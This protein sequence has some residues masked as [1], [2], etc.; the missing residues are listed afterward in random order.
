MAT[1]P[2]LDLD[3]RRSLRSAVRWL[4]GVYVL[5]FLV[6]VGV[7]S[8][9]SRLHHERLAEAMSLAVRNSLV[10]RD[11]R[12]VIS[13]LNPSI[14]QSFTEIGFVSSKGEPVFNLP[15]LSVAGISRAWEGVFKGMIEIPIAPA[16][17]ESRSDET[18]GILRFSYSMVEPLAVSFGCWLFFLAL[19]V[20][21]FNRVRLFIERRHREI[22]QAREAE[23]LA[24][25]AH[26]VSHDIRSPLSA[27][28]M[29]VNTLDGIPPE[30]R[31]IIRLASER[32][33]DIANDLLNRQKMRVPFT[34][35]ASGGEV[36]SSLL[37]SVPAVSSG[38]LSFRK[39]LISDLLRDVFSEKQAALSD[40]HDL[41]LKLDL[42][43]P[44][45]AVCELDAKEFSRALSNL[46]NNAAEAIEGEGCV[47]LALRSSQKKDIAVVVSDDGRGIPEA[48]LTRLGKERVTVGKEGTGSGSGVGV[49]HAKSV[50]EAMG[51][52]FSIQSR[53]GMGTMVTITLP[54]WYDQSTRS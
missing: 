25:V 20:P 30:R 22:V 37:A 41:K 11:L 29:V 46:I 50:I 53:I 7:A 13:V 51:G 48:V 3:L 54:L 40:R 4:V 27:L 45:E 42:N 16:S 33:N 43:G 49:F 14:G 31:S 1:A 44:T 28:N 24:A 39:I 6:M 19:A 21:V 2:T 36:A 38:N 17:L 10:V 18:I 34:G 5:I 12:Q 32:I 8:Y 23:L 35:G 9:S 26:Q 47:T 15:S 52:K